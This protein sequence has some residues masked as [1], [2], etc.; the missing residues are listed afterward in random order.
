MFSLSGAVESFRR[1]LLI[2]TDIL[3]KTVDG[4]PCSL[5]QHYIYYLKMQM[6]NPFERS[7]EVCFSK[8]TNSV[9]IS[10]CLCL[11]SVLHCKKSPV[12]KIYIF[13]SE[14]ISAIFFSLPLSG[15]NN[16]VTRF[17]LFSWT[18]FTKTALLAVYYQAH[19]ELLLKSYTGKGKYWFH[20]EIKAIFM[21]GTLNLVNLSQ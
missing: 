6:C 21:M 16:L 12:L 18:F 3:Q 5:V 9:N 13:F 10:C 19:V 17:S 1:Y 2:W 4:C 20:L 8:A 7:G 15:P 14:A 11:I